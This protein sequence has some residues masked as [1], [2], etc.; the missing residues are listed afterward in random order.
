[1]HLSAFKFRESPVLG[2]DEYRNTY[3]NYAEF[4][5]YDNRVS[6]CILSWVAWMLR[7]CVMHQCL[8]CW[9]GMSYN[10]EMV[11]NM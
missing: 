3:Y 6:I 5:S 2:K 7:M 4:E 10:G 1:M 9:A 11:I 8:T